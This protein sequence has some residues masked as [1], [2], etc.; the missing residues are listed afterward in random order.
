VLLPHANDG[1]EDEDQENDKRLDEC[2]EALLLLEKG[3]HEGEGRSAEEDLDQEVIKLLKD[4][5]P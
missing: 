3:E 4:E 1:V 5:L 2:L